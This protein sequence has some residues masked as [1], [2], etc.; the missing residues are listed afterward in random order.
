[1]HLILRLDA[2]QDRNGVSD[3]R[4]RHEYLLKTPRKR[5]ILLD[6]LAILP[7]RRRSHTPQLSASESGFEHLPSVHAAL[8]PPRTDHQMNLVNE[9]DD[10][11]LRC[12]HLLENPLE[13]L[14]KV[15]AVL[16]TG[17]NRRQ[18]QAPH[19]LI[20]DRLGHLSGH[21][22]LSKTLRNG[23]FAHTRLPNEHRVVLGPPRQHLQRPPHHLVPPDH[24]VQL[25]VPRR[26]G[27][28]SPILL[29]G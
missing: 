23:S 7:K 12:S 2:A 19:R 3:R 26:L 15:P 1:M 14:L 10:A 9:E 18:I 4:L 27:Q 16:G 13:P 24:G 28:I 11:A 20:P 21:N 6:V 22:T 25:P 5:R 8:A 29:E 17:H